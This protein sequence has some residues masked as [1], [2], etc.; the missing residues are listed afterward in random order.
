MRRF[1]ITVAK[2]P[3]SQKAMTMHSCSGAQQ[4]WRIKGSHH[5]VLI[6]LTQCI[7][8]T[9]RQQRVIPVDFYG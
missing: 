7:W 5:C 8:W 9:N 2:S 4:K 1:S 3:P 6:Y